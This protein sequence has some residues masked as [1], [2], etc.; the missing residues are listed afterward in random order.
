MARN[1]IQG[2]FIPSHPEKYEGDISK[3]RWRSSWELVAF[4]FCDNN[5][6]I[7]RWSS[8]ETVI[9]YVSPVDGEFHR[10]FVDLKVTV[11]RP[12]G[13]YKTILIEIKPFAQTQ[14]PKKGKK[15]DKTFMSEV[16]TYLVN[17][18]KWKYASDY[19]A[20][21]DFDWLIWTEHD[22][23]PTLNKLPRRNKVKS[24]VKRA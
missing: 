12:D 14:K 7:V 13:H 24:S 22:L 9:Q 5:P 19:C 8:E 11:R 10:Y 15:S 17:Q 16:Q 21:H 3:I 20:R 4:K 18:A 2:D 6:A 1:Y 23:F